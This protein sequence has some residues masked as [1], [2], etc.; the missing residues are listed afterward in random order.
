[1]TG[2]LTIHTT[3]IIQAIC[4]NVPIADSLDNVLS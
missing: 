3:T 4:H 1:M 2:Q